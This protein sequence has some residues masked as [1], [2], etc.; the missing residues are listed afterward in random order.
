MAYSSLSNLHHFSL[1]C[2]CLREEEEEEE[3][4][5]GGWRERETWEGETEQRNHLVY[6]VYISLFLLPLEKIP[7]FQIKK[8]ILH[9]WWIFKKKKIFFSFSLTKQ[10]STQIQ[11]FLFHFHNY[12]RFEFFFGYFVSFCCFSTQNLHG[13]RVGARG[14]LKGGA[15]KFVIFFFELF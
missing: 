6:F 5:L 10:N 14:R 12:Y 13:G 9:R 4:G 15:R 1:C 11:Q 2:W 7:K 3:E 8:K